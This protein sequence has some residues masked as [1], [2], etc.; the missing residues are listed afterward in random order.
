MDRPSPPHA[1]V[2]TTAA[3]SAVGPARALPPA[4]T[5]SDARIDPASL[6]SILRRGAWL[7]VGS[8]ALALGAAA[9]Y[10]YSS[11]PVYQANAMVAVEAQ[12]RG[13]VMLVDDTKPFVLSAEVGLLR[14]SVELAE[15][16]VGRLEACDGTTCR[17][18]IGEREGYIAQNR[19]WGV[20]RGEA[21]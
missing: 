9:A 15:R 4:P 12:P 5:A 13:A 3:E 20:D 7:I 16:V 10:T 2:P 21:F 1:L 19:L 18:V 14:N 17:I 6:L 11:D 8:V